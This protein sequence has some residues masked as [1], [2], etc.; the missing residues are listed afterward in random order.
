MLKA[1]KNEEGDFI[2]KNV[3]GWWRFDIKTGEWWKIFGPYGSGEQA[4]NFRADL[5]PVKTLELLIR[6]GLSQRKAELVGIPSSGIAYRGGQP[7]APSRR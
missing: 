7:S 5:K 1:Y 4:D 2:L 3:Y 6:T